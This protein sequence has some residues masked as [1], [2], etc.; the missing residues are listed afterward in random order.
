MD[1][2]RRGT[3]DELTA[4]SY[5]SLHEP[6]MEGKAEWTIRFYQGGGLMVE[7]CPLL[8]IFGVRPSRFFS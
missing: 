1:A 4:V 5:V 2:K 6:C 8:R 3:I 7:T